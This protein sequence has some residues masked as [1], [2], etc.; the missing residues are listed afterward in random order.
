MYRTKLGNQ[1]YKIK[2]GPR[3]NSILD[4][5][6]DNNLLIAIFPGSLSPCDIL[7]KYKDT[8]QSINLRTPKHIHWLVDLLIKKEK[9]PTLTNQ[10]VAQF[11]NVWNNAT[12]ITVR[13]FT[14]LDNII[15]QSQI[16]NNSSIYTPLNQYG[17]YNIDFLII[18]ME[19]L[20]I[21]EKTNN[22]NAYMFGNV[23]DSLLT[24][25]DLFKI[26]ST[27]THR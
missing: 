1:S 4:I 20:I 5:E 7:V 25:N 2:N 10:L 12:G 6:I 3:S 9:E 8:N 19:L 26:I 24:S 23:I 13:D 14:T 22:P 21:Q 27:A 15:K 18:L 16:L 17:Y 11:Q